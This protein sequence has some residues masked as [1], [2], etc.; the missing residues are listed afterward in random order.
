MFDSDEL[1][2]GKMS[3][4]VPES[5]QGAIAFSVPRDGRYLF[6]VDAVND[7]GMTLEWQLTIDRV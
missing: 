5:E 3:I 7:V 2:A 6:E 1:N 4:A